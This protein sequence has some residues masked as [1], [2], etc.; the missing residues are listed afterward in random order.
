MRQFVASFCT[1]NPQNAAY[2][3]KNALREGT[4]VGSDR[5]T[6]RAS[7]IANLRLLLFPPS[8][9]IEECHN[10]ND[11]LYIIITLR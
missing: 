9:K 10:N 2:M 3:G 5:S 8:E 11:M 4:Q 7:G 1:E 6:L